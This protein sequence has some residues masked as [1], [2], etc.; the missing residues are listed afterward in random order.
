MSDAFEPQPR[1]PSLVASPPR[2]TALAPVRCLALALIVGSCLGPRA[3]RAEMAATVNENGI[4]SDSIVTSLPDKGDP[5]GLR[6]WLAQRGITYTIY[7]TNEMLGTVSGGIRRGALYEGK[8]DAQFSADLEKLAGLK[9]LSFYSNIF[10][11]HGTGGPRRD[12]IG[13]LN[14]ISNIEALPTTRL[15]ELWLEQ[16][17]FNDRA[18]FRAGQLAVDQEFFTSDLSD[19]F[20]TSDWP[21]ITAS[22]LPSGGPAYPFATPGVRLKVEPVKDLALLLALFNGDPAGS[23]TGNPEARNRYGVAFRVN[24]PPFLIGEAQYKYN[25]A[26]GL[27]GTIRLGAWHHFGSFDDKR[28]GTD[29]LSLANPVSN[30][31]ARMLRGDDGIYGVIDQQLYR[32]PG[33]DAESGIGIF[34]RMSASPSDR[35]LISFYWDGG[36]VFS[37][38]IPGRPDDKFGATF[39]YSRISDGARALNQDQI[40]FTGL[41]QPVRDYELTLEFT[42]SAQIVPGWTIQPDFQYIFHPGGN[43]PDPT[44]P[45]GIVPIKDAAIIGLRSVIKY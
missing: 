40:A 31:I 30:G 16:K 38:L 23:G 20:L 29:G 14:T 7:Y 11:L 34:S 2:L 13:N 28:F 21:P 19:M 5:G 39:V 44:V 22:D 27:A 1:H 8:L 17:F 10:Q 3:A 42:Y 37:G 32:P 4:P 9:G 18:S 36:I 25:Q 45:S 41:P 6:K 26:A 24:D 15:S 33:G 43:I 35:N 12:F